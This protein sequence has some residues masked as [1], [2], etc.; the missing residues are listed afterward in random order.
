MSI[1]LSD[2]ALV[3]I[4]FNKSTELSLCS[5]K[6]SPFM[7]AHH[8]ELFSG[9]KGPE[10]LNS[11][12]TQLSQTSIPVMGMPRRKVQEDI[13]DLPAG[14]VPAIYA[15]GHV[16]KGLVDGSAESFLSSLCFRRLGCVLFRK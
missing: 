4:Q 2:A 9:G 13:V 6:E 14:L 8:R 7:L 11:P 1:S 10:G 15:P 3:L 16:A 12:N 5:Y